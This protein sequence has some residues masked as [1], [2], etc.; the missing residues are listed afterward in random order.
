[1]PSVS[2]TW[3]TQGD[4]KV[5]PICRALNNYTWTF[6]GKVPSSL[7]HHTYG[8]VWNIHL[9]S[10][11]HEHR[12]ATPRKKGGV[13]HT[14]KYGLM[15]NCRCHITPQFDLHDVLETVTKLRNDIQAA[16]EGAP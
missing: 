16:Q 13:S 6:T 7:N 4:D 2:I 5:C 9:G 3:H 11:A 1:M 10:L 8:E 12:F 14:G 15:S